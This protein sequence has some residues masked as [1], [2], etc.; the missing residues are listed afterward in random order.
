MKKLTG[1]VQNRL[2]TVLFHYRITPQTTTGLSPAELLMELD[3]LHPDI[4]RKV[5]ERQQKWST[6]GRAPIGRKFKIGDRLYARNYRGTPQW[7]PVTVVEITGPVSYLVETTTG[8]CIC[9]HVDQ[10][11]FRSVAGI[12]EPVP[13]SLNDADWD[14]WP[15]PY[16]TPA[17]PSP[18]QPPSPPIQRSSRLRRPVDRFS[19]YVS[20]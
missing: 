13:D 2:F 11:R 8:L 17:T 14:D 20:S 1:D 3:L 18:A 6:T 15:L 19:P 12:T 5:T 4:A 10:L 16:T 7:I 9:R